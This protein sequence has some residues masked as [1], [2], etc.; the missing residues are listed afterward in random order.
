MKIVVTSQGAGAESP[1]DPR[2]GRA[3]HLVVVDT[4]SRECET[5]DNAQNLHAAQ[6]AGVQT[7]QT[8]ARLGARAVI[9]GHIGPKAFATLQ[10]ANVAVFSGVSGTVQQAID[11]FN[12]GA[13]RSA[14]TADVDGH[15]TT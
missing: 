12:A 10:A 3:K 14:E 11:Q 5:H 4:E 6:G 7:A 13:L 1:V 2:F 8:A 15:W 9:T